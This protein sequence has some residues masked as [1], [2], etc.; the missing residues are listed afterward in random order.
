MYRHPYYEKLGYKEGLCPNAEKL[1]SEM[2]S[3]PLYYSLTDKDVD[4]VIMA[5]RKIVDYYKK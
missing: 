3:L 4:D 5:V 2:M 1:Y